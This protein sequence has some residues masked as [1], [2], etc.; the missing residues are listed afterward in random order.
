M[1][2]VPDYPLLEPGKSVSPLNTGLD[3]HGAN[4]F[5]ALVQPR[6]DVIPTDNEPRED[7]SSFLGGSATSPCR[8][9]PIDM[10]DATPFLLSDTGESD[11]YLL[12]H[13]SLDHLQDP[14]SKIMYRRIEQDPNNPNLDPRIDTGKPVIF[15]SLDHTL[16]DKYESRTDVNALAKEEKEVEDTCGGETGVRLV[17]LFFKYVY[18]YYPVV[19]RS[20]M[21]SPETDLPDKIKSLPLSLRAILCALGLQFMI[22][23]DILASTLVYSPPSA[24]ALYR[25]CWLAISEEIHT[26]HLSTL[27][28]CLL[29]LQ[30]ANNDQYVMDSPFRWSLLAWTISL[31]Q[32]LG[33]STDCTDWQGVP[34]W[35]KRLRRRLWWA[36]YSM[37]K[38]SFMSAGLPAHI[39]SEDFDVLPLTS[40]DFVSPEYETLHNRDAI[41]KDQLHTQSHFYHLVELSAILS[42]ILDTFF[43]IRASKLMAT[44]F[45]LTLER[46][47]PLRSRLQAWK[48]AYDTFASSIQ[49]DSRSYAR[50]DGNASLGL[51]YPVATMILFRAL[52]RPLDRP[53]GTPEDKIMRETGQ[54]AVRAGAKACCVEVVQY[55]EQVKRGAWDAFW[56]SCR[57]PYFLM[58]CSILISYRVTCWVCDCLLIYDAAAHNVDFAERN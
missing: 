23:D 2:T 40:L 8:P 38:W 25:I 46:A 47:R 11:P 17:K 57:S 13:Y 41:Q 36:L 24:H 31:A 4:W 33:L 26:P 51:A 3:D 49:N 20:G 10:P 5:N 48:L 44:N 7:L 27:Q 18:P 35:E 1:L 42:D 21:L 16:Y 58:V 34:S 45:A 30:R 6:S 39:K 28:S 53:D 12:K 32:S 55:L 52:L 9:N 54:D 14:E 50:L 37:E 56:H 43:S 15:M 29:L 22:F 19:S